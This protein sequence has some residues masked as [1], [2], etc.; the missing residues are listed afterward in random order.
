MSFNE[1]RS[2]KVLNLAPV[3]IWKFWHSTKIQNR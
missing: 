3:M 2:P 1:Y